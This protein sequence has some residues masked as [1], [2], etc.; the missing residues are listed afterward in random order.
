MGDSRAFLATLRRASISACTRPA[1]PL[2]AMLRTS[3]SVCVAARTKDLHSEM[4]RETI[5]FSK[6]HKG[7]PV[8]AA[9]F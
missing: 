7:Y 2:W 8:T 9:T 4:S 3:P 6:S 1:E 5:F